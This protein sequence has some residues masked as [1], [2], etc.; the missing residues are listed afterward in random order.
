MEKMLKKELSLGQVE[1]FS[2]KFYNFFSNKIAFIIR[3]KR[4]ER[5]EAKHS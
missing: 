2:F 5:H 3:I 1:L 4:P